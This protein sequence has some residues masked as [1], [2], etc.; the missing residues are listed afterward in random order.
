MALLAR[1]VHLHMRSV[2]T[3]V[4]WD[5]TC[6]GF[7]AGDP[8]REVTAIAVGWQSTMA[9]LREAKELGCELFITHEP[10]FYSH[11]DDDPEWLETQAARD[12]MAW[13]RETGMVVYRCHDVWDRFPGRGV[14]D[15]WAAF[16]GLEPACAR[17]TY[18]SVHPVPS[19]TV[20][21]L[22]HRTMR[23][24]EPLG[25]QDVHLIGE[26]WRMVSR[27][28]IGTGAITNVR[29][30][31]RLGADCLLVTNDG[32]NTWREGCWARDMGIPMIVVDHRTAEIPG[33]RE[34]AAYVGE[35]FGVPTRRVGEICSYEILAS[36]MRRDEAVRMRRDTLDDLP[37]VT[38]PANFALRPMADDE[39]WAYLQVMNRSNMA[40]EADKA[41]FERTFTSDPAYDPAHLQL[42]W[43]DDQPVAAA[44]AWHDTLDGEPWGMIHWVGVDLRE[45][46][47][48]LGKAVTAAALAVLRER[49]YRRAFLGTN[50]W[51]LPAIAAYRRLGF[52]PW[53]HDPAIPA[54]GG[55]ELWDRI[56][57]DL[58]VWRGD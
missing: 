35:Q 56:E 53:P 26:K 4:D 47:R 13:L 27:L 38:V 20:R 48:G 15:A 43:K 9:A 50:A 46:G 25:E 51:R 34:L 19:T 2:G 17:D 32:I 1:D 11:M 23:V 40:G 54:A 3:W 31:L 42:I 33:I 28:G 21:E 39:R 37:E 16:L 5:N 49:G 12:K 57:H 22:L 8:D 29:E 6:D 36:S 30:M 55:Q 18:H 44:G 41:W 14:L 58:E 52:E 10:T 24:V 45:R 7:K